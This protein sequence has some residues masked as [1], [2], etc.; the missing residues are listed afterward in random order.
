MIATL[1]PGDYT[2]V[3]QDANGANGVGIVEIFDLAP[4][5]SARLGNISTRGFVETGDNVM[6]GGI[7]VVN[8]PARIIVRARGP[9]LA[10]SVSNPLPNPTLELRDQNNLVATNNDW[11]TTQI[12]GA[13]TADQSQEIQNSGFAPGN[14]VESAMIVTLNR[15]LY[16]DCPRCE[17]QQWH[18]SRRSV[19]PS[20]TSRIADLSFVT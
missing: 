2:A 18:W 19:H 8:Q 1:P 20:I 3:V 14:S 15:G 17:R 11:Q 16:R 13:I 10:G 5:V 6:I 12:G 4:N 7:I 9:S